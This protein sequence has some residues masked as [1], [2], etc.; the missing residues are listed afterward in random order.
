[1]KT[2][3]PAEPV[4]LDDWLAVSTDGFAAMNA[5]RDA[6]H[7]TKELVQN[8]LDAID[9]RGGSV[10]LTAVPGDV[11]GRVV[12]TCR[13]DGHGMENLA[14]IRTVFH[15]S[16]TDSHLHRGRMGRGFKEM[17]CL[18][19]SAI[20]TS[21]QR[22]VEFY[23]DGGGKRLT[24]LCAVTRDQAISG[25]EVSML[26][27]WDAE[28]ISELQAYFQ[29]LLVPPGVVLTVNGKVITSRRP[30][31]SIDAKLP[32]ELLDAGRWIRPQRPTVVE[33]VPIAAGEEPSVYELGIPISAVQWDAPYHVNTLQRVPMNPCRDAV[34]SGY[35]TRLRRACL[36]TLLPELSSDQV[37]QDWVGNVAPLCPGDIQQQII[38]KGFGDN[39]ARS[40]PKMGARQFDEDARDIGANVIDTRHTSGGLRQILQQHVP[41]TRQLVE[42]H[43]HRLTESAVA[44]AF[45]I[46][47]VFGGADAASAEKRRLIESVGGKD[48]VEAVMDF[49][50]WFCQRLLDGY[51]GAAVCSVSLAL[52]NSAGAVATWSADDVLTLGIDTPWLW[53]DPL[54]EE[55]LAVLIHEAAHHLN[56]HHGR[57]FHRELE[58]LAGRAARLMLMQSAH[59]H[60]RFGSLIADHA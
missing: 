49:A 17:L 1:M 59:I 16:K 55:S 6:A 60:E 33:L 41:T 51:N 37:R 43:N 50:R 56:A 21:G 52:L 3:D 12:I 54:G 11:P 9:G 25:T 4:T 5:G 26:M 20:V 8:A 7:L 47:D 23:R 36:P 31:H 53:T 2:S 27:P 40:V 15:T 39:I 29:R 57:D 44:G 14:D 19:E 28:I 34:A 35:L 22:R 38:G 32:T 48:R 10:S 18:C 13:D 42:Q 24:R 30:S 58:K 46:T 45:G